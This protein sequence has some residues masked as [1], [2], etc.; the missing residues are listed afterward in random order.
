MA[1]PMCDGF[2]FS[3]TTGS[4]CLKKNCQPDNV[5]GYGLKTHDYYRKSGMFRKYIGKWP[6]CTNIR[7]FKANKLSEVAAKCMASRRCHGFSFSTRRS[8]GSGCLKKNCRPDN[9]AGYGSKSHDYYVKYDTAPTKPTAP[10]TSMPTNRVPA[11]KRGIIREY[12]GKWPHCTNLRCFGKTLL[13]KVR[14]MCMASPMCD[15]FSFSRTTGSGCLKKNCQPDNVNGYGLKTHDYYRK[16]GMFRKYIGK[17]PHCTNIRCFKANK[18]SEVAAKCMA[19]R[20]CHGF[21]FSTRRSIGS[22]CLKKNCRPDNVAGYGSKSHDYYV[23]YDAPSGKRRK[24]KS[25]KRRGKRRGRRGR[26]RGKR[27]RRGRKSGKRKGRR[28][29]KAG[30]QQGEK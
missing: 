1:S 5:N 21:S 26:K 18:L 12:I 24:G 11:L 17:W 13:S 8:I 30:K 15:G 3:R 7:C 14:G 23:K 4:G 28:G 29:R 25:G 20:R 27:G 9:V 22:G 10:P 19:S 16:S 6:H 2:S